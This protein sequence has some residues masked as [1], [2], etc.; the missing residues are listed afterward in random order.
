[1]KKQQGY[2]LLETLI[3]MLIVAALGASGLYGWQ[4]WQQQQRLWQTA[5]QVRDYLLQLR[6]DANWRNRDHVINVLRE[7]GTWCLASSA[8]SQASC[9]PVSL[10]I[11][12][13]LWADVEMADI[14]PS[15][16]FFGLRNTAWAGHIRLKNA[17]GEWRVVVSG[18]GRIRL[19]E[20]D[21]ARLC[22]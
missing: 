20:R 12:A 1:M 5:C 16:A 21:E 7:G 19:C 14:T 9:Q 22:Q 4:R 6:E 8:T 3:A 15:L 2:T 11:F 18:W 17:A 10:L 13:P